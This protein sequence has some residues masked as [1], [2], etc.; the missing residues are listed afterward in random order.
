MIFKIKIFFIIFILV[1]KIIIKINAIN[2][3]KKIKYFNEV[4][5]N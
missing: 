4:W 2:L 3:I 1:R 5:Y